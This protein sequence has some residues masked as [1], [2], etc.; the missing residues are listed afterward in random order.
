MHSDVLG[1][2][3]A[4]Q[5]NMRR[6]TLPI[7]RGFSRRSGSL[8]SLWFGCLIA[9]ASPLVAGDLTKP[10]DNP[11]P[12]SISLIKSLDT[13][14]AVHRIGQSPY[15]KAVAF[16]FLSTECPIAN[17]YIPEL[18]R[19][20]AAQR[21]QR[22]EFYGVISDRFVTRTAAARHAADYK[23]AF[24]VLF[25]GTGEL[26]AWL[27][28]K[29]T[30]EAFVLDASGKVL[31]RG[32]IDDRY[33]ELGKSRVEAQQ[34]DFSDALAAVIAGKNVAIPET[35][36]VGCLFESVSA[37][38]SDAVTYH[39]DV[40]PLL[41]ANCMNCHR[42]GEVAPFPLTSY[43]DARK[44][45]RQLATVT[46][47]KFMPPWRA[48]PHG[49]FLD[50]RRLSP[51]EIAVLTAWVDAGAPEGDPA[52][53]PPAPK[54]AEGWQLGEP[55]MIVAMP[56]EFEIPADGPD[57]FRVFVMPLDI[58]SDKLVASV[59]FRPGNRRVVH[60][61][62]HYLDSN[63]A[64]RKKD[65]ADPAPGYRSFGGPGFTPTG[66]LGGWSPGNTARF[67]PDNMGRYL[68]KGSDLALQIHYHPTGKVEKDRS[69]VGIHFVKTPSSKV[70]AGLMVLDRK[71]AIPA[72]AKRH[73]MSASYTLSADV[74]LV[75][76]APHM[77]LLGREMKATAVLPD[78][79]VQPLNWIKDWN[80]NWQDEYL[81]A[82]PSKL[83]KGTR[84]EV[85]AFYD[86]SADN[87]SNPS[88][89]PRDVRWGEQTTDEMFICFFLVSTEKPQD[90][91]PLILDNL[92]SL[93]MQGRF[94]RK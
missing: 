92:T 33:A 88:S 85:E 15:C 89:P 22:I 24:P 79:T 77:H 36:S 28:P 46:Q 48:E 82:H 78:G 16:V 2:R 74:T 39:R 64:A 10:V 17:G 49:Q 31:Y 70:V 57:I 68:K 51:H 32:R 19:I 6:K 34:H 20:Y 59:E 21:E 44:R 47:S 53:A 72:G 91:I 43:D 87:P 54:F 52:D 65:A 83:P 35:K 8:W 81:Y 58:P 1:G 38:T 11:A 42:A 4:L 94:K 26:A 80:F 61:A 29:H 55:D 30:P 25:D 66:A 37:P 13:T 60:H 63:G 93:A 18:N 73:P 86:N 76:V 7:F 50:E 45:A 9:L 3:T 5:S 12:P 75:G 69:M 14:G 41:Q 71:L 56:E 84:L 40:A 23:I 62:L 67:L 90:L 27:K